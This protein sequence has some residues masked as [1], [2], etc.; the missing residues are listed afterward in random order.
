MSYFGQA[1]AECRFAVLLGGY[2]RESDLKNLLSDPKVHIAGIA[3]HRKAVGM[4]KDPKAI[5]RHNASIKH[6]SAEAERLRKAA[7]K[8]AG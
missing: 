2:L 8:K 7:E 6:H 1:V 5:A 4:T 3:Y